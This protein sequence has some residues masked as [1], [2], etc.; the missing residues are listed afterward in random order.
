MSPSHH[1][2]LIAERLVWP[3]GQRAAPR[4]LG[5]AYR[6][7]SHGRHAGHGARFG[8]VSGPVGRRSLVGIPRGPSWHQRVPGL[9]SQRREPQDHHRRHLRHRSTGAGPKDHAASDAGPRSDHS[10][11]RRRAHPLPGRRRRRNG[12]ARRGLEVFTRGRLRHG[13]DLCLGGGVTRGLGCSPRSLGRARHCARRSRRDVPQQGHR[14]RLVRRHG[15]GR[16]GRL[17]AGTC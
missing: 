12:P 9:V 11:R 7:G 10:R 15:G 16:R 1:R 17:G 4:H 2:D 6:S 5:T 14:A 3:G 8:V 13:S